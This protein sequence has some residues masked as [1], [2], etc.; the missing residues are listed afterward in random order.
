ME[1]MF[2]IIACIFVECYAIYELS[3]Y[4]LYKYRKRRCTRKIKCRI[5]EKNIVKLVQPKRNSF[6]SYNYTYSPIN[7]NEITLKNPKAY[8]PINYSIGQTVD[9]FVSDKNSQL[10]YDANEK[11]YGSPSFF[12]IATII[13]VIFASIFIF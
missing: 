2:W 11:F 5:I 12:I 7:Q 8:V 1:N 6:Q 13:V 10:F 4:I 3:Q 9:I